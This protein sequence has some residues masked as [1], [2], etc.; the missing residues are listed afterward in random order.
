MEVRDAL[1]GLE[2]AH[3]HMSKARPPY[4]PHGYQVLHMWFVHGTVSSSTEAAA[5]SG[6]GAEA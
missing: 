1:A 2:L 3:T 5:C 6:A 4:P